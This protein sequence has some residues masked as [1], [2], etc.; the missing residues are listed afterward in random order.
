MSQPPAP[1]EPSFALVT[2]TAEFLEHALRV[3]KSAHMQLTLFTHDLDVRV[4][5]SEVFCETLKAFILGHRRAQLRVLVHTPALAMRQ[6]HRLVELGRRLSSRIEFRALADERKTLIEEY[7]LADERS[8]LCKECY[9]DLEARYYAH[10]PLL[11]R[12]QLR[13]FENLW[14]ESLPAREFTDLKL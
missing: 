9:S 14:Q 10:E 11:A 5:G 4:Y 3:L 8:L 1:A 12:Q 6:G 7:L 13:T 2:G